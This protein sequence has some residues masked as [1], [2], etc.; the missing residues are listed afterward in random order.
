[1]ETQMGEWWFIHF[2]DKDAYGR[3]AHLQPVIWEN[4]WPIIGD[5]KDG[6]GIGEPVL[7]NQRPNVGKTYP[8]G[9]PQI[10]AKKAHG[11]AL[12]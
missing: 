7:V 11:Q 9:S 6:D 1:M 3:I 10:T 8:A 4:G 2:Q 12:K 5:D